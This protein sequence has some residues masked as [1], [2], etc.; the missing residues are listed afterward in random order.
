MTK[1]LLFPL[2][3]RDIQNY[4]D[5]SCLVDVL[6]EDARGDR[7]VQTFDPALLPSHCCD[8]FLLHM[9][10]WAKEVR[11]LPVSTY[12]VWRGKTEAAVGAD[13]LCLFY[14]WL[15]CHEEEAFQVTGQL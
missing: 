12:G 14:A 6:L 9:F 5:R 10:Q 1:T 11:L 13:V 15:D 2:S 8:D 4:V 3:V 7:D